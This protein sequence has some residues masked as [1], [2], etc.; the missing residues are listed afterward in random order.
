MIIDVNKYSINEKVVKE[1][2]LENGD[3]K[4][5]IA[6]SI[7]ANATMVPCI[8]VAYWIGDVSG[9]PP[10]VIKSIHALMKFYGY[11]QVLN[12]PA[13]SPKEVCF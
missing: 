5:G 8:V 2:Y 10:E 11:T 1:W 12:I 9:W 7:M 6:I 13:N 3:N 4:P